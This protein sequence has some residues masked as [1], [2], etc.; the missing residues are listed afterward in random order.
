LAAIARN[1]LIGFENVE[2]FNTDILASKHRLAPSIITAIDRARQR[3]GGR[4]LL[5]A[6]L[7]YHVSCPVMINLVTSEPRADA[8]FVTVQKEVA[9]RMVGPVGS[10]HYG[11]LSILLAATGRTERLRVLKPTVFWPSPLVAS[12][13]VAFQRHRN[14]YTCME[15]LPTLVTVVSLFMQHRRKML[16]AA[17]HAMPAPWCTLDWPSAFATAGITATLRPDQ[18]TP[19]QFVNLAHVIGSTM[20]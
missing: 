3:L 18:V 10:P 16:K 2:L 19:D 5:V 8:M 17:I 14:R 7:P 13:M 9:D 1:E 12:A 4:F 15:G 20:I 6:N 11:I